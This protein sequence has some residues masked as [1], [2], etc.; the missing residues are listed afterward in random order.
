M[1]LKAL[2]TCYPCRNGGVEQTARC[3]HVF[4]FTLA[5]NRERN[6]WIGKAAFGEISSEVTDWWKGWEQSAYKYV[7][8]DSEMY[9]IAVY[10]SD[11][12]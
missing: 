12:E 6:I 11:E 2:E 8:F 5:D 1:C 10:F 4:I 7:L 9:P 3:S